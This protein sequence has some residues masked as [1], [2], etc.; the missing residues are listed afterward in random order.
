VSSGVAGVSQR[1][2]VRAAKRQCVVCAAS[3]VMA[4]DKMSSTQAGVMVGKR[5][6]PA[7]KKQPCFYGVPS[8]AA[9]LPVIES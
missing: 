7:S 3:V 1:P 9:Y 6:V 4:Y 5:H 2:H 8:F